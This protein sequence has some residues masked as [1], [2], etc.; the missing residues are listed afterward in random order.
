MQH[1]WKLTCQSGFMNASDLHKR[2]RQAFRLKQDEDRPPW[3]MVDRERSIIQTETDR[4]TD[5]ESNACKGFGLS[6]NG[7]GAGNKKIIVYQRFN[8]TQR[9]R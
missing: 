4:Q 6:H 7:P 8:K 2:T 3:R 5:K 9:S 1:F